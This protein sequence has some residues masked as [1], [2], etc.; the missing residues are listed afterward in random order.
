MAP[1][2]FGRAMGTVTNALKGFSIQNYLDDLICSSK[3]WEAHLLD[4][5]ALF[6]QLQCFGFTVNPKKC[7]F[8]KKEV[9]FLGFIVDGTGVKPDPAKVHAMTNFPDPKNVGELKRACGMLNFYRRFVPNYSAL[10]APLHA[11]VKL[12][13]KFKWT[14]EMSESL[15]EIRRILVENA[16]LHHPDINK[17][18]II[19]TDASTTGISHT[20]SQLDEQGALRPISFYSQS[21]HGAQRNWHINEKECFSLVMAFRKNR[22]LLGNSPI[23]CVTDNLTT[24]Y[25]QQLKSSSNAKI[26]RWALELQRFPFSIVHRPGTQIRVADCLSRVDIPSAADK[27]QEQEEC[28]FDDYDEG[29]FGVLNQVFDSEHGGHTQELSMQASILSVLDTV[30]DEAVYVRSS[31]RPCNEQHSQD[32]ECSRNS[33]FMD[34]ILNKISRVTD[35]GI[36]IGQAVYAALEQAD[37]TGD[38]QT[39]TQVHTS[40]TPTQP[41][42]TP[43][44]PTTQTPLSQATPSQAS[45][46]PPSTPTQQQDITVEEYLFQKEDE[47]MEA[48]YFHKGELAD[49]QKT[50]PFFGPIYHYQLNGQLPK[51]QRQAKRVLADTDNWV[52]DEDGLLKKIY[53]PPRSKDPQDIV[54]LLAL[55]PRFRRDIVEAYHDSLMGAHQGAPRLLAAIRQKY[56][57]P[58][59]FRDLFEFTKT[60]DACQKAKR[61]RDNTR[62]P[63]QCR[64]VASF[65]GRVHLDCLHLP[66]SREGYTVLLVIIDSMSKVLELIP[67]VDETAATLARQFFRHWVLRYSIPI[68]ITTDRHPSFMGSFMTEL[69]NYL[70]V[71]KLAISTA[72]PQ[73]NGQVE[74]MNSQVLNTIR[75]LVQRYPMSWPDLLPSVRFGYMSS[76]SKSTKFSPFQL[77]HGVEPRF[78]EAYLWNDPSSVPSSTQTAMEQLL[79]ELSY[80][81]RMAHKN[82][83]EAN[84]IHKQAYDDRIQS[85]LQ[86]YEV[87]DLVLLKDYRAPGTSTNK[88][89]L[90]F[91]GPYRVTRR[92]GPVLYELLNTHTYE[93]VQSLIHQDRIRE[94][95]PPNTARIRQLPRQTLEELGMVPD[96]PQMGEVQADPA[97]APAP[98]STPSQPSTQSAPP[99]PTPQPPQQPRKTV[100]ITSGSSQAEDIVMLPRPF[101]EERAK[102][103]TRIIS[104]RR[105]GSRPQYKCVIRN[106]RNWEWLYEDRIPPAVLQKFLESRNQ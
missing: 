25:I 57:W 32:D 68:Q 78:P 37:S 16:V 55:P 36:Y 95:H 20:I 75:S 21:L 103:V 86:H 29:I 87:G 85:G 31:L 8:G 72:H 92:F 10:S 54:F 49:E 38:S 22:H 58:G 13:R 60:C 101:D 52:L 26:L 88:F 47:L 84:K 73:A 100:Q 19:S 89:S 83:E 33:Q 51:K 46:A 91:W 34:K 5:Q 40:Q 17:P 6:T 62:A 45:Q 53:K 93:T 3:S 99:T 42:H 48:I 4:L 69:T 30:T 77:L 64:K 71:E 79:P 97:P 105:I 24:R 65:M 11:G 76:V 39:H 56:W 67:C 66:K 15:A 12:G 98:A 70:G 1:H 50:D 59:Q 80:Y 7:A 61:S 106:R 74:I 90:K 35:E 63:M 23:Y 104:S 18:F 81:R 82:L 102:S 43:T 94:Y 27:A 96:L 44:P 14:P 2:S 9:K 28:E 41:S